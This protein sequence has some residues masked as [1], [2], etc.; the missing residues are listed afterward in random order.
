MIRIFLITLVLISAIKTMAQDTY[1]DSLYNKL[2]KTIENSGNY[3]KIREARIDALKNGLKHQSRPMERYEILMNLYNEYRPYQND[4][5]IV[6]LRLSITAATRAARNDLAE[7]C[8]TL[9]AKQLSLSGHYVEG[10][11]ELNN[12]NRKELGAK[13][14]KYYFIAANHIYGELGAYSIDKKTKQLY[15]DKCDAYRDSLYAVADPNDDVCIEKRINDLVNEGRYKDALKLNK[16]QMAMCESGSQEFA[17]SAYYRQYIYKRMGERDSMMYWLA[18]SAICDI[19]NAINDQASLWSLAYELNNNDDTERAYR[20]ISFAWN[21]AQKFDTRIR[22]WQ[23]SPL[24]SHIDRNLQRLTQQHN[25]RLTT[26]AT[27]VSLLALML[28]ASLIIVMRQRRRIAT[29]RNE[30]RHANDCLSVINSNLQTANSVLTD[31]NMKLHESNRVKEEYIGRFIGI[32]AE[33]IDK[34]DA[35]RHE[36]ARLIKKRDYDGLMNW[37]KSTADKEKD[38]NEFYANFDNAFLYLFPD[39]VEQFNSLLREEERILLS[40][41][42]RLNTPLRIYAFIRLGI[43]NSQKIAGFLHHSLNTIYN[44]RARMRNAA[45]GNRDEFEKKVK[46]LGTPT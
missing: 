35:I 44:Y 27:T 6:Y 20:Y 46:K 16:K 45:L 33:N 37:T 42:T 7:Y 11:D 41:P 39:F 38:R 12:I 4:S 31:S 8:H 25:Q 23:I 24:L 22:S 1:I 9:I 3:I 15:F 13:Y 32:C 19:E 36:I 2:D 34:K 17:L 30:L 26:L 29:A 18:V 28:A 43:D 21:A 5:A 40:N 10:L 14:V